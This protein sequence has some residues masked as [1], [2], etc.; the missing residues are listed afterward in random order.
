MIAQEFDVNLLTR[1]IES[2]MSPLLERQ[3]EGGRL[4][5]F[6]HYSENI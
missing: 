2:K 1:P 3:E 4:E 5:S 6:G